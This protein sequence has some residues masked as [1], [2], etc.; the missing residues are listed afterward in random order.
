MKI[1][2]KRI[3]TTYEIRKAKK[4]IPAILIQL[5]E[6][7]P[8]FHISTLIR[9]TEKEIS[10]ADKNPIFLGVGFFIFASA[11]YEYR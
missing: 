1:S 4:N 3:T 9:K 11:G 10:R 2:R 7:R 8:L 5:R 6:M